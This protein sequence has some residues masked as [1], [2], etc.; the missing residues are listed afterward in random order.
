MREKCNNVI[1]LGLIVIPSAKSGL[2]SHYAR[3]ISNYWWLT[4]SPFEFKLFFDGLSV[5][6]LSAMFE[7]RKRDAKKGHLTL[8]EEKQLSS[9]TCVI[10]STHIDSNPSQLSSFLSYLLITLCARS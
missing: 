1:I 4:F 7:L 6:S 2:A 8:E 5:T 3:P 10:I 9:G